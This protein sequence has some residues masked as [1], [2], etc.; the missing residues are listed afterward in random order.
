MSNFDVSKEQLWSNIRQL[1][2]QKT[3]PALREARQMLRDWMKQHPEDYSSQDA[4]ESLAMMEEAL[5]IIEAEKAAE[6][7]AA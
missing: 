1:K 7:I 6:L 3:L 2:R 5:E 4:G